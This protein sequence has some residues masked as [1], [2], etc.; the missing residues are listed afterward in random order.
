MRKHGVGCTLTVELSSL[1]WP[2]M[3]EIKCNDTFTTVSNEERIAAGIYI[4]L[5]RSQT[6]KDS[7][8]IRIS[9]LLLRNQTWM[10]LGYLDQEPSKY[11]CG[12][13]WYPVIKLNYN[14]KPAAQ[15]HQCCMTL[16]L[17]LKMYYLSLA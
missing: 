16:P 14:I 15:Q 17:S 1:S 5:V 2:A 11:F 7:A 10:D 12:L 13:T 4:G 9:N 3:I 6:N 8:G